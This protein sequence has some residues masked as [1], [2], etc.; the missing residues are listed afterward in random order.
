MLV[1]AKLSYLRISPRKAR[2]VVDLIRGKSVEQAQNILNFTVKGAANPV[3]KLLNSAAANAK[4]NFSLDPKNMYVARIF[5]NE[6]ATY[7]RVFPRSRGSANQIQK[8]TCHIKLVL[9]EKGE[10]IGM[11]E[12]SKIKKEKPVE[13]ATEAKK[14]KK[15]ERSEKPAIKEAKK[16]KNKQLRKKLKN[17]LKNNFL[18]SKTKN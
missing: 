6:G 13:A 18:N 8:K 14:E 12:K 5:V 9:A 3:L 17:Q 10:K 2:L 15:S 4:N 7:K 16:R 1:T 11:P